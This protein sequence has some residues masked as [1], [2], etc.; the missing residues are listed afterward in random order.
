MVFLCDGDVF[1]STTINVVN[2]NEADDRSEYQEIYSTK[3]DILQTSQIKIGLKRIPLVSQVKHIW[4]DYAGTNFALIRVRCCD[5]I[6]I[7]SLLQF[8][9]SFRIVPKI[10]WQF[11]SFKIRLTI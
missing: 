5:Y 10:I 4:V 8:I 6:C 1:L 11:L 3:K 2:F 9:I 7:N